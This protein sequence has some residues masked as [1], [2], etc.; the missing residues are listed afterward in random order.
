MARPAVGR[1]RPRWRCRHICG[2]AASDGERERRNCIR[3]GGRL[4]GSASGRHV[5][6]RAQTACHH[7]PQLRISEDPRRR[8]DQ[9]RRVCPARYDDRR[10]RN[11]DHRDRSERARSWCLD[12]RHRR[13]NPGAR[14]HGDLLHLPITQQPP[15][16]SGRG[17]HSDRPVLHGG[18][19][20]HCHRH[21]D[22][23]QRQ[24][25]DRLLNNDVRPVHPDARRRR[26]HVLR[27]PDRGS[28][29]R[30]SRRLRRTTAE[31]SRAAARS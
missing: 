15:R 13:V 27:G 1:R 10:H 18:A 30:A 16:R 23:R 19:G 26:Q 6:H 29:T 22:H 12:L 7:R 8:P 11:H 4:G 20:R 3:T 24:P 31:R 14:Q 2:G 21:A 28:T 5:E 17:R 25:P 9:G